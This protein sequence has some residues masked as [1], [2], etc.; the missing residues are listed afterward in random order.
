MVSHTDGRARYPKPLARY[1][2]FGPLAA[3]GAAFDVGT[4][5]FREVS[6]VVVLARPPGCRRPDLRLYFLKQ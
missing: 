1:R 2:A 5:R 4:R 6:Q 3:P